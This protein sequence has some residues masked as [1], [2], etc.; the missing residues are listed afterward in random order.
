DETSALVSEERTTDSTPTPDGTGEF[1]ESVS[2][3]ET[4][5]TVENFENNPGDIAQISVSVYVDYRSTT[6]VDDEGV[7]TVVKEPWSD[8]Q[9]SS[10]V[11]IVSNAVGYDQARGDRIEVEQIEFEDS[12]IAIASGGLTVRATVVEGIRALFMGLALLGSLAV[13]FF[14]LR[15]MASTLDPSKISMKA[16]REFEKSILE[17]EEK[18]TESERDVLVKRIIKTSSINPE[19][20]A[21]TL[22]TFFKE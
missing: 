19:I 14:I 16:E 7:Q 11:A 13:F 1:E 4:G 9:I 8:D 10:M 6:T 20:A 12:E 18:P 5:Q 15:S 3:Y 22:K 17:E 21:K 2:N